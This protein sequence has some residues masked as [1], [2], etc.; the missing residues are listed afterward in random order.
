MTDDAHK[1][2]GT[3]FFGTIG[4]VSMRRLCRVILQRWYVPFGTVAA[5]VALSY[6]ICRFLPPIYESV[7]TFTMDMNPAVGKFSDGAAAGLLSDS[8]LNYGELFN[9]RYAEWHSRPVVTGIL[10]SYRSKRPTSRLTDEELI[11]VLKNSRITIKRDSRLVE[12]SVRAGDPE[13]CTDLAISYVEAI[14]ANASTKG[15]ERGKRAMELVDKTVETQRS[16]LQAISRRSAEARI[17]TGVDSIRVD[18]DIATRSLEQTTAR[19]LAMEG[20]QA[21]LT[22]MQKILDKVVDR[23]AAHAALLADDPRSK[24][25]SEL[26]A[27]CIEKENVCRQMLSQVTKRHPVVRQAGRE[28]LA[29]LARLRAACRRAKESGQAELDEIIP[30]IEALKTRKT[31]LE[32]NK[33]ECLKQLAKAEE[34]IQRD[35]RVL[36]AAHTTMESLLLEQDRVTAAAT[37]R[38][39]TIVPGCPPSVPEKPVIPDPLVVYPTSIFIFSLLG[40]FLA[41]FM[42]GLADPFADV[43]DVIRRTGCPILATLPHVKATSRG[44][45][46]RLLRDN[47]HSPFSESVMALLGRL[48]S[49]C[50]NGSHRRLLVISTCPGEGKTITSASIATSFAKSGLRTLL[51]DFDLRRPQQAGVWDLQLTRETSLSHALTAARRRSPDFAAIAKPSY[52]PGLDVIASLPPDEEVDPATAVGSVATRA[53]FAWAKVTYD[54]IVVDAPPFG[55]VGDVVALAGMTDSVIL[56]CR[57]DRTNASHLAGCVDY[58]NESGANILGIVVN[59]DGANGNA[60]SPERKPAQRHDCPAG[61]D[62]VEFDETRKFA[63]ED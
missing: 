19:L 38:R 39:E 34:K 49:P 52:I 12:I 53:F 20:K 7:A 42:D 33:Q 26:I 47:P 36:K 17:A 16:R 23:P 15:D 27:E 45:I 50:H 13:L 29:A 32:E 54:A 24:E 48:E 41:L 37:Q 30:Q 60:F 1:N 44:E 8:A 18:L 21:Q 6:A 46:I 55:T 28:L 25:I 59:D 56:M 35:Q 4:Q 63:D 51:A 61:A 2:P 62:P 3:D 40:V 22:E 14:S 11:D 58:L 10:G 5:A 9:T 43:W 57:P 31:E